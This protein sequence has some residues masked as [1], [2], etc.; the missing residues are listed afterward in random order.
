MM[1]PPVVQHYVLC[2]RNG[3]ALSNTLVRITYLV[4]L[5]AV[6]AEQRWVTSS[7]AVDR[8]AVVDLPK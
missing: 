4:Q 8:I 1:I 2:Y 6:D 3:L 5:A 7:T